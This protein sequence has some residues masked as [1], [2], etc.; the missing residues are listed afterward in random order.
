[1]A[2]VLRP[3]PADMPRTDK[4]RLLDQRGQDGD[5]VG[6]RD[7]D[8]RACPARQLIERDRKDTKAAGYWCLVVSFPRGRAAPEYAALLNTTQ[9]SEPLAPSLCKKIFAGKFS[10]DQGKL[11]MK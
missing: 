5:I 6:A 10:T 11:K 4:N 7:R 8:I 1:M 9:S 2:H 3:D